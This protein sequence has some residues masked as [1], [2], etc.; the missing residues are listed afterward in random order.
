ME[1]ILVATYNEDFL[2][3]EMFCVCL[4][5]YWKG[6]KNL[7]VIV[8]KNSDPTKNNLDDLVLA[9]NI[10]NC[11]FDD[12]WNIEI[13]NGTIETVPAFTEMS[14]NK[15]LYSDVNTLVCDSK[16]FLLKPSNID[17]YMLNNQYCVN[18]F[19]PNQTHDELYENILG[20]PAPAV[21]S[22]TP[23]IWSDKICRDAIKWLQHHH[24]NYQTWNAFPG[25]Y[26]YC[27]WFL[28]AWNNPEI[29]KMLITDSE[30]CPLRFGG[31]WFEQD[32]SGS[33]A[34]EKNFNDWPE[35][36]WWKHTRKVKDIGCLDTTCRVLK[37]YAINPKIVD[38]WKKRK[39]AEATLLTVG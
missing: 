25:Y 22:M 3:F 34:E 37:K 36:K 10:T 35:R 2:Q 1:K 6:E 13:V 9:K 12:T 31:I 26:E 11:F 32:M 18:F 24:G 33:L 19:F 5:K 8:G 7:T 23:W 27:I 38:E 21:S 15:L 30:K 39:V 4:S 14:I 29:K 17:D 20:K 16:D 28:Y